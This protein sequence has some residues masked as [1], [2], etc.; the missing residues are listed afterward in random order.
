MVRLFGYPEFMNREIFPFI[1]GYQDQSAIVDK[2]LYQKYRTARVEQLLEAKLFKPALARALIE[3]A[4]EALQAVLRTYNSQNQF[5]AKDV[6]TL[7]KA[8]GIP[9]VPEGVKRYIFL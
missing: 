9:V 6:E 1:I 3:N 7:K 4:P 8:M 5:P 2:G